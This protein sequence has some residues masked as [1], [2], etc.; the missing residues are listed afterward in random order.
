[1]SCED[2]EKGIIREAKEK[3]ADTKSAGVWILDLPWSE[4]GE[5]RTEK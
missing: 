5:L 3:C 4:I 1:M 2:T